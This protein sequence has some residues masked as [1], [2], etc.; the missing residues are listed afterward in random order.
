MTPTECLHEQAVL[1]RVLAGRWPQDGDDE[2][3]R[4]ADSCA[5]CRD[6]ASIAV[7]LRDD[8]DMAMRTVQV[9]AAG[10]VWWR[11]AVRARFEATH[12]AAR[13][14]AWA[15][16]VAAAAATGLATA[17]VRLA[18]PQ[19]RESARWAT[20]FVGDVEPRTADVVALVGSAVQVSVPLALA[21]ALCLV[22]APLAVYFV[23]LDD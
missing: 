21:A 11:A 5:A 14:M 23:L 7:L 13:P 17:I 4:H 22:I 19:L 3:R 20:T 8:H 18:W 12:A 16:G 1:D 15:Y 10:Q 9:P 6:A 2:L